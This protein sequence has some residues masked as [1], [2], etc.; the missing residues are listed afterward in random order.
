MIVTCENCGAR[1]KLDDVKVSGRGVKITCPK[2]RH[3]FVIFRDQAE[4]GRS[5]AGPM[6]LIPEMGFSP[7][8]Q[9]PLPPPRVPSRDVNTL[10]FRKVGIASWK[11]KVKIGL[12]YDFSDYKTLR[13]YIQDGRV[14]ASDTLSYD[15]K[16]WTA[17]GDI[18]D[19]ERHFVDVYEAAEERKAAEEAQKA[20]PEENPFA[21]ERTTGI[22]GMA[23]VAATLGNAA[24]VETSTGP[25]TNPGSAGR[26]IPP[27][28]RSPGGP[29]TLPPTERVP[30]SPRNTLPPQD[31]GTGPVFGD[32]P[33]QSAGRRKKRNSAAQA[34][35]AAEKAKGGIGSTGAI[36]VVGI[37]ALLGG[38]LYLN[39]STGPGLPPPTTPTPADAVTPTGP[40]P[41]EIRQQMREEL[42]RELEE[43]PR[44]DPIDVG[45]EPQL[46][47]VRPR[48]V[49]GNGSAS[50]GTPVR[51]SSPPPAPEI[52]VSAASSAKDNAAVG[53][54]AWGRGD[55]SGALAAYRA[56]AAMEPTSATYAGKVG[57]ALYK[58]GD[59]SSAKVSLSAARRGGYAEASKWL[60]HIARDQGDVAG[61]IGHYNDY[62]KGSPSDAAEIRR[63]IETLTGS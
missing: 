2:C 38:W 1:Y 6:S 5:D 13:K 39:R 28:D 41:E 45:S 16:T 52:K 44:A 29:R 22:H 26:T 36:A 50:S 24:R 34:A 19:L 31:R 53:D 60:G 30:T 48:G 61:A 32:G 21:D 49:G 8:T 17:I 11:V 42:R 9:P 46:I 7:R 14:T 4:A 56:A 3:I 62:L 63:E 58:T 57:R 10:D 40:T 51:G 12:V 43:A 23:D 25:M 59:L 33:G 37:L 27:Q 20:A 54:D 15:G 35:A 47:P 55:Y 18:P